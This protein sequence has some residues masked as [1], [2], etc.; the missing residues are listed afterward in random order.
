MKIYCQCYLK[1]ICLIKQFYKFNYLPVTRSV[2]SYIDIY[3]R[4]TIESATR[5]QILDRVVSLSF[6]ANDFTK[7][8][9]PSV[10]PAMGT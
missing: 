1:N 5:V 2:L 6:C 10:L 8:I 7:G 3:C 4:R 9:N